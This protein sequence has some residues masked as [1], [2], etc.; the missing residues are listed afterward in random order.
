MQASLLHWNDTKFSAIEN[1]LVTMLRA[2]NAGAVSGTR[3]DATS[4]TPG[5]VATSQR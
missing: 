3:S 5:A 1:K 2:V 4:G